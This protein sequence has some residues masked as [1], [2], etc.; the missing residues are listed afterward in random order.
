MN[1]TKRLRFISDIE[2]YHIEQLWNSCF[3]GIEN[4]NHMN[5]YVPYPLTQRWQLD[6]FL[7]NGHGHQNWVVQRKDDD[8][9][10][11]FMVYGA[12]IPGHHHHI[13]F[14]IGFNYIRQGYAKEA[15]GALLDELRT[16]SCSTVYGRCFEDNV[17]SIRTMLA[18]G[19][20]N[21]GR[22]GQRYGRNYEILCQINLVT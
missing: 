21:M 8:A 6:G 1:D 12:F 19:F 9:F 10:I 14:N 16:Q 5:A 3:E 2:H 13:G 17:G 15:L 18:S 7:R 11:G 20:Q 4:L 22:T